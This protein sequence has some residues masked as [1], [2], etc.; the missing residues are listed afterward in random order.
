MNV[1]MPNHRITRN[2]ILA[3][4]TKKKESFRLFEMIV[5]QLSVADP[6]T[7]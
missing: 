4:V 6:R 7:Y 1:R 3:R 2:I 5:S